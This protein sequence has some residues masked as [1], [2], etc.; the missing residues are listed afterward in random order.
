MAQAEE[1]LREGNSAA[2]GAPKL[3]GQEQ[4]GL[5]RRSGESQWLGPAWG[6]WLLWG[7]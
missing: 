6:V 2:P 3:L 4:L 7:Q 5:M 1:Q